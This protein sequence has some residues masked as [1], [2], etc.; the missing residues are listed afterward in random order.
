[1]FALLKST[2]KIKQHKI[3]LPIHEFTLQI[4]EGIAVF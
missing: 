1:L 2:K 3:E 4:T